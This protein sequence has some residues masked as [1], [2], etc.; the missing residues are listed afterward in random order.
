[1]TAQPAARPEAQIAE[2]ARRNG[3]LLIPHG[4]EYV[5]ADLA[6]SGWS[7]YDTLAAVEQHLADLD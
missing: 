5:L 7:V 6:A 1:M 2:Q 4:G 3:Y